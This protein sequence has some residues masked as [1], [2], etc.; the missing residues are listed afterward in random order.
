[1]TN[2]GERAAGAL[3]IFAPAALVSVVPRPAQRGR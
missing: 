1:M 3:T 2:L